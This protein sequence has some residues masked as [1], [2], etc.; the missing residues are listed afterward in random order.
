MKRS[1]LCVALV[2]AG[3]LSSC[4]SYSPTDFS[5]QTLAAQD[6]W[7]A[8]GGGV[9]GGAAAKDENVFVVSSRKEL[10]AAL[11]S[12][13][14]QPKII[15]V[16]GTI[17]LSMDDAGRELLETDYAVAPYNFDDYVKAYAPAV[18]N[19]KLDPKTKRP[20]RD[21]TGPQ[22]EAREAS[23]KR[24]EAQIRISIPSN[25][26]LI[27]IGTDAKIIKGGLVI[28]RRTTSNNAEPVVSNVI[29]RNIEFQ[30][31]FDY[32]P[33]WDPADS[34]KVDKSYPGCQDTYVDANT[35]PQRCPGGRWNSEYD[36]VWL[37]GAERV[38][39][40]HCTFNDGDR[41]D[42]KFPP[43]F[44]FP[45]NEVTQKIQHH[46]GMLDITLGSNFVT[47]SNNYFH[48]HDK[49]SLLGGSDGLDKVDGGKLN[50][51]FR[52]NLYENA[53]QRLP[54]VRFGQVHT[55]N[56]HYIGDAAGLDNAKFSAYQNHLNAIEA[57]NK[58]NIWRGAFGI[59]KNSAIFSEN[60]VF[61]IKHGG[62]DIA[63]VIQGGTKF[64][65]QGSIVNGQPA[66][67][68]KALNALD[69]K[70]QVSPDL[71]WKPAGYGAKV[72]PA[73]EVPAYVKANA[74]AGKL[75]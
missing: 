13:G 7:A 43:N 55:Y 10:V 8:V 24:Q 19:T 30:D 59:G 60:N 23:S 16:K 14:D 40:D 45:H 4:A 67:I 39:V 74:G 50:V 57:H 2:T 15:K 44:P 65:D 41:N 32:F 35:G 70:K 75:K 54:R 42:K 58:G 20:S 21:L 27:G 48:D 31:A 9:T 71:G 3:V 69:P 25:T 47:V 17:N 36:S 38:W 66:D 53:G 72:L 22:E 46:D 52:H 51:T 1:M 49:S 68:V 34:W 6:G 26:T 11:K 29:I 5:R 56:N 28:G 64:L 18:W 73:A 61:D 62:A 33:Q 37:S 12:A 63:A